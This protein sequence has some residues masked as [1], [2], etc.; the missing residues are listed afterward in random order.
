MH[1][2]FLIYIFILISNFYFYYIFS[3]LHRLRQFAYY[4][5]FRLNGSVVTDSGLL[6]FLCLQVI[7][8]RWPLAKAETCSDRRYTKYSVLLDVANEGFILWFDAYRIL[9]GKTERKRPLGR[10][11]RRWMDNIKMYLRLIGWGGMGWIDLAQKGPC[12]GFLWT[13]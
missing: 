5:T 2:H 9:V 12:G 3:I 7:T 13:R 6:D 4:L 1:I 8:W 10:S 11:R